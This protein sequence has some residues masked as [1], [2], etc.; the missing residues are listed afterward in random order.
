MAV[1]LTTRTDVVTP[2]R[3]QGALRS[4]V[5]SVGARF[6]TVSGSSE[7]AVE[8]TAL[9]LWPLVLSSAL[10]LG[11]PSALTFELRQN[12]DNAREQE[13][14][15]SAAV[16]S[17][18]SIG[19]AVTAAAV[20]AT[21]VLLHHYRPE[22]RHTAAWLMPNLIIGLLLLL[23]RAAL[24]AEGGFGRSGL[25]LAAPPALTL[26]GLIALKLGGHLSPVTAGLAYTFSGLPPFFYLWRHL[27][28]TFRV[29][30]ARLRAAARKLLAYGLRSY[31]IDLCGT[32][33]FYIDQALVVGLL[34]PEIMGVYVVALSASRVLNVPHLA[35]ASVLFPRMVGME[36]SELVTLTRRALRIGATLALLSAAATALCGRELLLLLYG[37]SFAAVELPLVLLTVEAAISGCVNILSQ[38]FMATGRPG[39]V[40]T[41]QVLGLAAAV[42]LLLLLIPR[43][44]IVGASAAVLGSTVIRF[45]FV[46]FQFVRTFSHQVPGLL[47]DG[48]TTRW[49]LRQLRRRQVSTPPSE[50]GVKA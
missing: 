17:L 49:L 48:D 5:K 24:E 18:V 34:S 29:P 28:F 30:A 46:L 14:L 23:G 31:A 12:C 6:A 27:P 41:L 50:L 39:V 38:P 37:P 3:H 20:F 32:M 43:W 33:G 9:L 35:L 7:T 47:L 44:G 45:S 15:V 10:S 40:A 13:A 19:I 42:P 16:L 25:L 2:D 22:I 26:L 4:V 1:V 36:I 11:L 21:P 8:L